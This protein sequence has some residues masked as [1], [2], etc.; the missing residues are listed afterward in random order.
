ML[1][2]DSSVGLIQIVFDG[3]DFDR[4]SIKISVN[5]PACSVYGLEK[6]KLSKSLF[7]I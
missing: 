6:T 7:F 2:H 3:T 4:A 1:V 5:T